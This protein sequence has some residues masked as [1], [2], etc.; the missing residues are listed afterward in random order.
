MD[1]YDDEILLDAA[2]DEI[3]TP[4]SSA[5]SDIWAQLMT[6]AESESAT[7][8][9]TC[10]EPFRP[11]SIPRSTKTFLNINYDSDRTDYQEET[12][13]PSL[14][15]FDRRHTSASKKK[16]RHYQHKLKSDNNISAVR[17]LNFGGRVEKRSVKVKKSINAM[18]LENLRDVEFAP[19]HIWNEDERELLCVLNRWYYV[20][21]RAVELTVFADVFNSII[22][23]DIKPIRVRNQFESYLRLH[24]G[25]AFP[26]FGRVFSVPFDDPEGRYAEI[27]ALIGSEAE[28]LGH[29]LQHRQIDTDVPSGKAKFAKSPTTRRAYKSLVRRALQKAKESTSFS[30]A[31]S[32][33]VI[34]R[35]IATTSTAV[36][37]PIEDDWET[38]TDAEVS[39]R[40]S[41]PNKISVSTKPRLTFRVWDAE[42]RTQFVDSSFVAQ[43]FVDWPRPFPA[44][45][46]IDDPSEAGKILTVLHLS[47]HGDTPVYIS[48][49]SVSYSR[50]LL[51][52]LHANLS[53]SL[54]QAL[55]Y[56]TNMQRPQI[57][58]I[59][60]GAS[61]LQEKNKVY[62]AGEVFPWLKA[63]GLA[64]W[65]RYKGKC[66]EGLC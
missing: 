15:N 6:A 61:S 12:P 3:L 44:P 11:Q 27:R 39:P 56:A 32:A 52:G 16:S 4:G 58:L 37:M 62:H 19:S 26:E 10:P 66:G 2:S 7:D 55:S 24:G 25:N 17:Y 14:H 28:A 5:S 57:A 45:V 49:A 30:V 42:N 21:D 54:L 50:G 63:Q 47:K 53:Q 59:D 23:S 46:A 41:T 31:E 43:A 13:S 60:L 8:V 40:P 51:D 34:T 33:R 20:T 9:K 35:S 22:A 48:T 1:A 65:A 36:N 18:S 64:R 29:D 38:L